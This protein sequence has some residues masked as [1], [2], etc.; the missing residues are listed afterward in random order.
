MK[1]TKDV[2]TKNQEI[3]SKW[4]L[5]DHGFTTE[6]MSFGIFLARMPSY[7]IKNQCQEAYCR[8]LEGPQP[9]E[10]SLHVNGAGDWAS[11]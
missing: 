6:C 10:G 8:D 11:A 2:K 3:T 9:L 5:P 4:P 1:L 7:S